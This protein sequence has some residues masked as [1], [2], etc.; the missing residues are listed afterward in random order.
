MTRPDVDTIVPQ[1]RRVGR[2]LWLI[3]ERTN[4]HHVYLAAAGIAF[5]LAL[6]IFP[7]VLVIVFLLGAFV[8]KTLVM[9]A[10]EQ[11]FRQ[12][13]PVGGGLDTIVREA[14]REL[15]GILENY[16]SAGWIGIPV[17][18]WVSLTLF[19]SVRAALSAVF[20]MRE[21]GSLV[22]YII[23]DIF[24]FI[25]FIVLVLIV[26]IFPLTIKLFAQ[27]LNTSLPGAYSIL[28]QPV[29][30]QLVGILMVLCFFFCLFRFAPNQRPPASVVA[31][32]A[33]F[34]TILWEC[35]R[36]VFGWYLLGGTASYGKMYGIYATVALSLLWVYY[37]ALLVLLSAELA[38]FWYEYRH[39]HLMSDDFR[40]TIA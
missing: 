3:L 1:A 6:C 8:E 16:S 21:R 33:I 11:F 23:K 5:N 14:N 12:A 24:L 32:S 34:S 4:D 2:A 22:K 20:S 30:A 10:F 19:T 31:L 13:L 17:L 40:E 9:N 38:R 27:W 26:N 39:R 28:F 36:M 29:L 7:T 15:Q 25:L 35:A 18:L 37:S